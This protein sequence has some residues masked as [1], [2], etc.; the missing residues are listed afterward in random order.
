[1][2]HTRKEFADLCGLTPGNL[3]NRIK[4]GKVIVEND[5][6]DDKNSQNAYFITRQQ[7][8][9]PNA[10][11]KRK[12]AM[13]IKPHKLDVDKVKAQTKLFE[14][15]QEKREAEI[16]WKKQ[17]AA[18]MKLKAGRILGEYIPSDQVRVLFTQ[19]FR[20]LSL[21]IKDMI[22]QY[23]VRISQKANLKTN[24][25]AELRKEMV[26]GINKAMERAQLMTEK[27]LQSASADKD[28]AAA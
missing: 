23:I 8:R 17:Q 11:A 6:I 22:D 14:L 1:M 15:D 13:V 18:V 4:A 24:D 25:V 3:S 26:A 10:G 7:Q 21:T 19:H 9:R 28:K 5:K 27:D 12:N 16:D 2:K 20:S